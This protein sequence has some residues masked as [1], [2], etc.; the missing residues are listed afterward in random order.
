M[1]RVDI[2]ET[3]KTQELEISSI[4][5]LTN[6]DIVVISDYDKGLLSPEV[7]RLIT[8]QCAENNIPVVVDS[9]KKDLSCFYS[10]I[11]KIN[12]KEYNEIQKQP[13]DSEFV[14][15]SMSQGHLSV[16]VVVGIF[17]HTPVIL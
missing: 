11:M 3:Q 8:Q 5:H 9:K 12:Q 7:C 14:L 6:Y 1:L 10:C 4:N 17:A 13:N 16:H 2:N 15:L